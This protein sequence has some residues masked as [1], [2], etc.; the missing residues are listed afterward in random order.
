[1]R[2]SATRPSSLPDPSPFVPGSTLDPNGWT[3]TFL[4][5]PVGPVWTTAVA[6]V[7]DGWVVVGSTGDAGS[8]PIAFHSTEGLVWEPELIEGTR[9]WPD[10]LVPW[11][12]GLL[13]VGSADTDR[14]VDLDGVSTWT[15]GPDGFWASAGGVLCSW[16]SPTALVFHDRPWL[17]G[18]GAGRVPYL[19][20]S[21]DG[22]TW[23]DHPGTLG[24][25]LVQAAATDGRA[26]WVF[27]ETPDGDPVAL[28]S[29]DGQKF[30]PESLPNGDEDLQAVSLDDRILVLATGPQGHEVL[31]PR[32]SGG[33][34]EQTRGYPFHGGQ[35]FGAAGDRLVDLPK[36]PGST[37]DIVVSPDGVAWNAI[38]APGDET[39]SYADLAV[40]D[41]IA[42]LV[43]AVEVRDELVGAIWA[44]PASLLGL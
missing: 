39:A 36:G 24:D 9:G 17:I 1:V 41:G 10:T 20:D 37:A 13:A 34:L 29:T 8:D 31:S 27:A 21:E 35:R 43:G 33:W 16:A 28:R 18:S 3:L 7:A 23:T 40:A 14:C 11:R 30:L 15:R 19:M 6:H 44:A 26:L 25:V 2:A 42:V 4:G 12:D 38:P 5:D 32:T 22:L